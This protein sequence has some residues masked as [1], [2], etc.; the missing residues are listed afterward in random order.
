MAT[1]RP[2]ITSAWGSSACRMSP[3]GANIILGLAVWNTSTSFATMLSTPGAHLGVIAFP[4]T[5]AWWGGGV[6]PTPP[7]ISA[8]WLSLNSGQGQELVMGPVPEPGTL[9][10]VG[11]GVAALLAFRRR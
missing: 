3:P 9:S 6:P 10:L 8:G 5:T 7:D 4:Q 2:A 1:R 11:L